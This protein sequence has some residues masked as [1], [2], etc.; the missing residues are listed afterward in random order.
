MKLLRITLT[1]LIAT[2]AVLIY[3]CN[4]EKKQVNQASQHLRIM[5]YNVWAGFSKVPERKETWILSDHL[6]V[7]VDLDM[8]K[9]HALT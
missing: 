7:L 6:P 2:L 4:S 5:S 3:S 8:K 1:A 9:Q